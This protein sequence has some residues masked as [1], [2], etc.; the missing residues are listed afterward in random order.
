MSMNVGGG[1]T[2][3]TIDLEEQRRRAEE[4]R[5]EEEKK[6]AEEQRKAEAKKRAEE[7][8]K[9][10]EEQRVEEE[11]K[12]QEEASIFEEQQEEEN[13]VFEGNRNDQYFQTQTGSTAK[14]A[15]TSDTVDNLNATL[16]QRNNEE[17]ANGGNEVHGMSDA[18]YA[19]FRRKMYEDYGIALEDGYNY[20]HFQNVAVAM[21][22]SCSQST[23]YSAM[24][25]AAQSYD[26]VLDLV[27]DAKL[28]A[29]IADIFKGDTDPNWE[30]LCKS[31]NAGK[32]L[33]EYG[34]QIVKTGDRQYCFSLVDENGNVIQDSEGHLAQVYKNDYLM[35]DGQCQQNEVNISAALDAMGFDCMSVLDLSKEEYQ[36][37]L[38]M[39]Q[40]SNSE[41]GTAS[42]FKGS[43]EMSIRREVLGTYDNATKTWSK[44]KKQDNSSWVNGTYTDKVTGETT[45]AK[46]RYSQFLKEK[47][48]GFYRGKHNYDGS[49]SGLTGN[50]GALGSFKSNGPNGSYGGSGFNGLVEKFLKLGFS[51]EDALERAK[52]ENGVQAEYTGTEGEAIEESPI[53]KT[54]ADVSQVEYD[55]YVTE[56][57]NKGYNIETAISIANKQLDVKNIEYRGLYNYLLEEQQLIAR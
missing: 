46:K 54:G 26:T 8:Q 49:V 43:D 21:G 56:L 48:A 41:L 12:A 1:T 30:S 17:A 4:R 37:V 13:S 7:E 53:N 25:K 34:I 15:T 20:G 6:R 9:A 57:V 11:Q 33:K 45:G 28:S 2:T 31:G 40:M 47:N 42:Q 51:L 36:M 5:K 39:A 19:E 23:R 14:G 50:G 32:L 24:C 38:E 44:A 29:A 10:Q 52:A 18:E 27:L 16:A 22:E 3:R 35:P 55:D